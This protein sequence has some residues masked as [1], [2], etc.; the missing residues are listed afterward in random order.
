MEWLGTGSS[1]PPNRNTSR[2]WGAEG[3]E[4]EGVVEGVAEGGGRE[5]GREGASV[6]VFAPF[7]GRE[8]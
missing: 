5:G 1:S 7:W 3:V 8:L 2:I 4:R 6:R